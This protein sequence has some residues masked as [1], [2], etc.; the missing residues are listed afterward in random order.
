MSR[1][2]L[3]LDHDHSSFPSHIS[4]SQILCVGHVAIKYEHNSLLGWFNKIYEMSQPSNKP[5]IGHPAFVPG[6]PPFV[7]YIFILFLLYMTIG[8]KIYVN[9]N[10]VFGSPNNVNLPVTKCVLLQVPSIGPLSNFLYW[11]YYRHIR[12]APILL[13]DTHFRL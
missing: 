7:S 11:H 5:L 8:T 12:W 6:G 1:V 2:W 3:K 9:P 10:N 4:C 13:M